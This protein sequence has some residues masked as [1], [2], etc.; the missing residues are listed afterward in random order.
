MTFPRCFLLI[1]MTLVLGT[2]CG[3]STALPLDGSAAGRG[4]SSVG[5]GSG[6]S[7]GGRGGSSAGG[8]GG[9]SVGADGGESCQ[10]LMDDYTRALVPAIACVPGAA[11]Q[12]QQLTLSLDCTDCYRGV[13]DATTVDA[14]RAQLLG[15]GCIT[16][17]V[18]PCIGSGA[19]TCA[20]TDAGS[21]SGTC[22]N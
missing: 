16:P 15:Q 17:V 20:A 19:G 18:C 2:G 11:D 14:L 5:G 3:S 4:G 10:Q 12:C 1:G 21:A 22:G 13:E 6:S 9:S 8:R 7:A